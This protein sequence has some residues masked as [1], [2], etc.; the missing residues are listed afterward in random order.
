MA[1]IVIL[2]PSRRLPEQRMTRTSSM[3]LY[4]EHIFVLVLQTAL[5]ISVIKLRMRG[6][7]AIFGTACGESLCNWPMY[8][9]L[10]HV[11]H[12]Q[13]IRGSSDFL[14]TQTSDV[15]QLTDASSEPSTLGSTCGSLDYLEAQASSAAD[16]HPV[17]VLSHL[18]H[19]D[20][21]AV[22]WFYLLVRLSQ[23]HAL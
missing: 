4:E 15:F 23:Y 5:D 21:I 22:A 7:Y 9:E 1:S 20:D 19:P 18:S 17:P 10:A 13:M 11:T 16:H 3:L 6:T 8:R 12:S 14:E 2:F